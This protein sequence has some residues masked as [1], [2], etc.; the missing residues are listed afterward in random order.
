MA[1]QSEIW[2]MCPRQL[3]GAGAYAHS[4]R[5]SDVMIMF[6]HDFKEY[7]IYYGVIHVVVVV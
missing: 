1:L 6:Y 4:G 3:Y 2:G 5:P 7:S